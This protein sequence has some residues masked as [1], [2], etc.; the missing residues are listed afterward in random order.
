MTELD[1]I[2]NRIRDNLDQMADHMATGGCETFDQYQYCCGMVKGLAVIERE[3]IDL[4][5]R[6]KNAE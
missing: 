2:R 3:I 5:E 4:E 6:M 1:Y